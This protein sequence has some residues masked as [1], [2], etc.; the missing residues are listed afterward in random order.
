VSELPQR[1]SLRRHFAAHVVPGEGVTLLS[2]RERHLLTGPVYERLIP[3]LTGE[4]SADDLVESLEAEFAPEEIYYALMRLRAN[5]MVREAGDAASPE[6]TAYWDAAGTAP[7]AAARRLQEH[8]LSVRTVGLDPRHGVGGV[9]EAMG[10]TVGPD[11]AWDLLVVDDYLNPALEDQNRLALASARPWI[12][13]QPVGREVWVG[14]LFVPGRSGCWTCLASRLEQNQPVET[15]LEARGFGRVGSDASAAL[16]ATMHLAFALLATLVSR[17]IATGDDSA[18][19]GTIHAFDTTRG[20]SSTHRVTRRPQCP[21]C[22]APELY[23]ERAGTRPV[24]QARPKVPGAGNDQRTRDLR[25]TYRRFRRHLGPV[26]GIIPGLTRHHAHGAKLIHAV[27]AGPN[28]GLRYR[29]LQ[30]LREGL[31]S[32]SAGKGVTLLRAKVSAMGEALER[33]SGVFQGDEPRVCARLEEL[34]GALHPNR[35]MHVSEEQYRIRD[36]VNPGAW[37]GDRIPPPFEAEL[38]TDWTA[39][40]S[41][42][43]GARTFLPTMLLYYDHP[44]GPGP[45]SCV[46]TTNGAAAGNC[47]EEAVLHGLLELIERDCVALWW[48][49]RLR[50]PAVDIAALEDRYVQ[51]LRDAYRAVG[52]EW[53]VLDL[54]SDLAI[55]CFAAVSRR[56]DGG[57]EEPLFG[58]GAHLD[59]RIALRRSLTELN[60]ILVA[61]DGVQTP[62]ES[63][64]HLVRWLAD[65]SVEGHAHLLPASGTPVRHESRATGDVLLDLETCCAE[66]TARGMDPLVLD[67]TRPDVGVPVAKVI[68]PELRYFRP[69]FAPGRLYDVP[70]ALGW[71]SRRHTEAELNPMGF[72]L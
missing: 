60:Q 23:A 1:P 42:T 54:T 63:E 3:M 45:R 49:N 68:V 46:A 62:F 47:F 22:G 15:Y 65:G 38:R 39:L 13:C 67:Q 7:S 44:A 58:F 43:T 37:A 9:L 50:R 71:L 11:G 34:P 12:L 33:F 10:L 32:T 26:T 30:S 69:R 64:P 52:R 18:L 55:P 6:T 66:L 4:R 5:D 20:R 25:A 36:A 70:V 72:L 19:R 24:L 59:P 57:R 31:A 17:V 61:R 21:A 29:G 35:C 51:R 8:R 14:P 40:W 48:Y 16:P 27:S 2:G 28:V 56:V 53:W 41:L